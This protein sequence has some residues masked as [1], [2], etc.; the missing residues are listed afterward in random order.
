MQICL[1]YNNNVILS[2]FNTVGTI[3]EGCNFLDT[4]KMFTQFTSND[5]N[6]YICNSLV[7]GTVVRTGGAF[8]RGTYVNSTLLANPE[9]SKLLVNENNGSP[10]V[11]IDETP[12][13]YPQLLVMQ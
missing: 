12:T 9:R 1:F 4:I 11:I 7:T 6:N 5:S 3:I 13:P 8:A 2:T 10:Q